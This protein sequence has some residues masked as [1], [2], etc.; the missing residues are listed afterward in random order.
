MWPKLGSNPQWWDDEWFRALKMS[1]LN[2]LATVGGGG[3]TLVTFF[4]K[5]YQA[6]YMQ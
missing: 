2:H 3:A 4:E 1:G 5:K 6:V